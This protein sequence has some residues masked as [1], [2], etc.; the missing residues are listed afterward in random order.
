MA[1]RKF[2]DA[3]LE[4]VDDDWKNKPLKPET[5]HSLDSDEDDDDVDEE[6][7]KILPQDDIEGI[8]I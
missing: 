6:K 3:D 2:E 8:L 1:K 5:K 4:E 7:Y